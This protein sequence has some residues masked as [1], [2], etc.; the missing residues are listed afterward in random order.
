MHIIIIRL[1]MIKLK[2]NQ[3]LNQTFKKIL[4]NLNQ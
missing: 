2:T 1:K 3:L 4:F